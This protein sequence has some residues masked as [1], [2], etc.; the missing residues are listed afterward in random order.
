MATI[1]GSVASNSDAYSFYVKWS[2]TKESDY[3]TTNKTTVNATVYVKCTD[4]YSN[5]SGLLQKLVIDGTEFTDSISVNLTE[6]VTITLISGSKTI[7]HNA[8]GNKKITISADCDL[9][10]GNGYGPVWGSASDEVSLMTIPREATVNQTLK[11]KTE[12]SITMEW[13]SDST[14]SLIKYS[15]DNG[16]TWLPKDGISVN[17][18]SGSYVISGL[19]AN[20]VYKIKTQVKRKDNDLTTDSTTK[21]IS[22]Y[23]YPHTTAVETDN[24][25]IGNSQTL[26][27]Y[28]PLKRAVTVKMNKN[29]TEGTQLYSGSTSGT[30]ITFTPDEKTLYKSIPKDSKAKCVYSVTYSDNTKQ[31]TGSYTYKIKGTELPTFSKY[32]YKDT[33]E[34]STTRLTGEDGQNFIN[35]YNTLTVTISTTNKAVSNEL[36]GTSISSYKLVCGSKSIEKAYSSSEDITLKLNNITSKTFT[37]HAIDNRG[38]STGVKKTIPTE[39]WKDY[40]KISVTAGKIE[41]TEQVNQET[42][43]T[44]NGEIWNKDFG[45]KQ[46]II[47]SCIYKYKK[48]TESS[49]TT[50]ATLIEPT[51]SGDTFSADLLIKGDADAEGFNISNSYNVQ[52]VIKDQ[53]KTTTYNLLL[54]AGTPGIAIHSNGV[55]FG[56]PYNEK[57]GGL[58]QVKN[59]SLLNLMY[60][61]NSVYVSSSNEDPSSK[62]GGTWSLIDK[63]F[64]YLATYKQDSEYISFN[65]KNV[66]GVYFGFTREGHSIMFQIQYTNEVELNDNTIEIGTVNFEDIGI[67]RFLQAVYFTGVC[68]GADAITTMH[69]HATSGLITCRDVVNSAGTVAKGNYN[70]FTVTITV[71]HVYML[72]EKCNRFYWKRTA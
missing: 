20:T 57:E 51:I 31:T 72:D 9:P 28:N 60:P 63:E 35:G 19:S 65:D 16:S 25:I 44:F 3:I 59:K 36:Y 70:Y 5:A 53:I 42:R 6:G 47:E 21:S 54:N 11:S 2:E 33:L 18:K 7:T 52:V 61:V 24:L 55:A 22:T 50:G 49:Y 23:N 32:T 34:D 15:I 40:F 66:S 37:V 39:N 46:N 17:A 58:I 69:M 68:D 38:L 43:L 4:H 45:K 41:R 14:I 1:N 26:T 67:S 48:T 27:L 13:S 12:T 64:S 71:P 62:I 56:A 29:S 10:D 30:S 8:D